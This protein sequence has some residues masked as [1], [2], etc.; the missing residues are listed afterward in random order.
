MAQQNLVTIT[1]PDMF[2]KLMEQNL[3]RVTLLNFWAPWAQ[4]CERMNGAV[5]QYAS[6]YPQAMF[7]NVRVA[8]R[9]RHALTLS[10]IHI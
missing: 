1:S 10:L 6:E 4:P 9:A 2:T 8:A 5:A 3:E 7:M